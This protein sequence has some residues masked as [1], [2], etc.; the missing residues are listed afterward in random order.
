M[1]SVIPGSFSIEPLTDR[2]QR[3][4]FE[5]GVA[6][7]DRYF[8]MQAGQDAKRNAAAPF[9]L[10]DADR[11]VIGYYTLSA[12]GIRLGELPPEIAQ[13]LPKYP[14]LPATLLGRLAVSRKY[15][16]QKLG[17]MLLIDA[18]HR[19]WNN[20]REVGSVGVVVDALDER[21]ESFYRHHEFMPL[22]G[23]SRKL[24]LSMTTIRKLFGD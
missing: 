3:N 24:F 10:V 6:E 4:T 20:T 11:I 22:P 5:S 18:L 13:K 12:N 8:Q 1:S 21:A 9:V 16:G 19:S 2:H 7:L 14:V 17:Q 23:Y 15:Q